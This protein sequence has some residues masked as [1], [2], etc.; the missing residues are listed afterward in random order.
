[1]S[2]VAARCSFSFCCCFNPLIVILTDEPGD[3]VEQEDVDASFNPLIVVSTNETAK[4]GW[5]LARCLFQ[6]SHRH[7]DE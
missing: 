7:L 6:P 2:L 3:D 5:P 1:M 4:V